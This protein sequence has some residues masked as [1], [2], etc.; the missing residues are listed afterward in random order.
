[1]FFENKNTK[2]GNTILRFRNINKYLAYLLL[3]VVK[4]LVLLGEY[5]HNVKNHKGGF[6]TYWGRDA[7]HHPDHPV[8]NEHAEIIHGTIPVC[9]ARNM[10][11][12]TT[13][14]NIECDPVPEVHMVRSV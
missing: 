1:M 2:T 14:Q 12:A 11:I 5:I 8:H 6:A 3:I 10:R 4:V 13:V 7:E 9:F